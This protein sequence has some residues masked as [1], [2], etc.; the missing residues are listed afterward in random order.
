MVGCSI[1]QKPL[2]LILVGNKVDLREQRCVTEVEGA[3]SHVVR[4]VN[5]AKLWNRDKRT[6]GH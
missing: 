2:R 4:R 1:V 6:I 3:V 5:N